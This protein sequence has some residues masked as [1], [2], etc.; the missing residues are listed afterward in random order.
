VAA[1]EE[2]QAARPEAAA[3]V[4]AA[5]AITP[6]PVALEPPTKDTR[7]GLVARRLALMAAA[8]AGEREPLGLLEAPLLEGMAGLAY[9][10]TLPAQRLLGRVAAAAA[11][12]V[13]L[14]RWEPGGPGVE[15]MAEPTP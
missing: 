15:R 7:A 4:V 14:T 2:T 9:P 11:N 10:V 12:K 13:L 3:E 1:V 6:Q 8:A 5:A